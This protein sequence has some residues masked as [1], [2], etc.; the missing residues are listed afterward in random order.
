M[1]T[2]NPTRIAGK[3]QQGYA[4]DVHTLRSDF[5][6]YDAYGHPEFD[7]QRSEIG[8]LLYRLKY[9]SDKSIL[10]EIVETA[11]GFIDSWKPNLNL[12]VPTPPSRSRRAYQPV[13]EIVR[14]L[15]ARI[16]VP[17]CED[18]IEKL[19]GTPELKNVYDYDQRLKLLEKAFSVNAAKLKGQSI[20]LFDDLYRSGATL[21]AI[22]GTMHERVE[23][24]TIYV[25]ALTKTRSTS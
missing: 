6:G 25:L 10:D 15:S 19:K 9:R 20:L 22:T 7:T 17:F 1:V 23:G 16:N 4:L 18:C 8:E 5:L 12:I 21:N 13:F 14:G 24:I 2:I 11:A 3:W